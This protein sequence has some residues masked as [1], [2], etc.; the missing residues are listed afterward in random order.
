[1]SAAFTVSVNA[2]AQL[3]R[4]PEVRSNGYCCPPN[5]T[6]VD[7]E[8]KVCEKGATLTEGGQCTAKEAPGVAAEAPVPAVKPS[9][10]PVLPVLTCSD[11]DPCSEGVTISVNGKSKPVRNGE[12]VVFQSNR[13][14]VRIDVQRDG[15]FDYTTYASVTPDEELVL[16]ARLQRMPNLEVA[17][18]TTG[19]LQAKANIY[20]ERQSDDVVVASCSVDVAKGTGNSCRMT[21]PFA[22]RRETLRLRV[23]GN[24]DVIVPS[25]TLDDWKVTTV[26][27]SATKPAP[28]AWYWIGPVA[29]TLVTSGVVAGGFVVN[30]KAGDDTTT[31]D[32]LTVIGAA[33]TA[34]DLV[35]S[36]W[37]LAHALAPPTD[38]NVDVRHD[39][40]PLQTVSVPA[41][42]ASAPSRQGIHASVGPTGLVFRW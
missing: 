20:A 11:G 1:L 19:D 2:S 16:R 12:R 6:F 17:L 10:F 15:Y 25:V 34:L 7:G 39:G 38:V 23:A 22:D 35:V 42:I 13:S 32:I 36:G 14:R 21:V 26:T 5:T 3:C 4:S 18:N 30:G 28:S 8:C 9:F 33:L 40:A 27:I 41:T 29:F 37:S 24:V 31:G